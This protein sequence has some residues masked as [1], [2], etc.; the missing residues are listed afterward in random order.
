MTLAAI[1]AHWAESLAP[2]T[3]VACCVGGYK[4]SRSG[5]GQVR[6]SQLTC[7]RGMSPARAHASVGYMATGEVVAVG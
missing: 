4:S 1:S 2:E 3:L 5:P 6:Q 7:V